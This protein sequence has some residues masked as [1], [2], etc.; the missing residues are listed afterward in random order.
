MVKNC[1][2]YSSEVKSQKI[3]SGEDPNY[4]ACIKDQIL[5]QTF[6]LSFHKFEFL[7]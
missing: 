4:L 1:E 3:L 2:L 5:D 7:R 6:R